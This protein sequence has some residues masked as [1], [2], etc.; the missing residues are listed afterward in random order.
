MS[1]LDRA[2]MV[3][4]SSL[5]SARL[6]TIPLRAFSLLFVHSVYFLQKCQ[7][8]KSLL[9]PI[10]FMMRR[11]RER[12]RELR[13]VL[14]GQVTRA[15]THKTPSHVRFRANGTLNRHGGR[16]ES[17]PVQTSTA[18]PRGAPRRRERPHRRDRKR[19]PIAAV[20]V[21]TRAGRSS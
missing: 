2:M 15:C 3:W 16:S 9:C 20:A 11:D 19:V 13:V 17:D 6:T 12:I 18:R 10:F 4:F 21:K 5:Q 7:V 8:K 1:F 14:L